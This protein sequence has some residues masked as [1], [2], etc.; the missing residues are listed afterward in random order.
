MTVDARIPLFE[1]REA[2]ARF[3]RETSLDDLAPDQLVEPTAVL[4]SRPR[5]TFAVRLDPRTVDLVRRI[6][7]VNE[8]GATQQVRRWIIERL[9]L[10]R[11]VGALVEPSGQLPDDVEQSVR[12][13]VLSIFL[14]RLPDIVD[15]AV[16][17]VLARSDQEA[18]ALRAES[19]ADEG[20]EGSA[21]DQGA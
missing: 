16:R 17:D 3:W 8:V 10:E 6:A 15:V 14:D 20:E 4:G 9:Q 5:S 12:Q 19:R 21:P 18:A 11:S 7:R 2:E 1:S 13:K